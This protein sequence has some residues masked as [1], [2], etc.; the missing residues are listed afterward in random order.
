M[1]HNINEDFVFN[2]NVI[3]SKVIVTT[4]GTS[5]WLIVV[6][7]IVTI[8]GGVIWGYFSNIDQSIVFSIFQK[9]FYLAWTIKFYPQIC[10]NAW[11]KS[12]QGFS[13]DTCHISLM[14][15]F[16]GALYSA[17]TFFEVVIFDQVPERR[18][19]VS[20]YQIAIMFNAVVCTAVQLAQE[21][22]YD[23]FFQS[24]HLEANRTSRKTT[25]LLYMYVFF[26]VLYL[27]LIGT[28]SSLATL[29]IVVSANEW[30]ISLVYAAVIFVSIRWLPQCFKSRK[31]KSFDG[32]SLTSVVIENIGNVSL[33]LSLLVNKEDSTGDKGTSAVLENFAHQ[34]VL[35]VLAAFSL[36]WCNLLIFQWYN[37]T[38]PVEGH[39]SS[40]TSAS[41]RTPNEEMRQSPAIS[42]PP[43]DD[44]ASDDLW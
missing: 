19:E 6:V 11:R 20:Q 15:Y 21:Y 13:I 36:F 41:V 22:Y 43:M 30:I 42:T 25:I 14:G 34:S 16:C 26:N 32:V 3:D 40:L 29:N 39:A 44:E 23:G 27:A 9:I 7:S 35:A 12:T 2:D 1:E 28:H 33:I 8:I 10:L 18:I 31:E 4:S 37:Y 5:R 38:F 17:L 24:R